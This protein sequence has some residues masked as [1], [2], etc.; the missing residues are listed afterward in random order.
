[1]VVPGWTQAKTVTSSTTIS[2][3][4]PVGVKVMTTV[5]PS[6]PGGKVTVSSGFGSVMVVGVPTV[7]PFTSFT[8]TV[9]VS[10]PLVVTVMLSSGVSSSET[11]TVTL[12]LVSSVDGLQLP[13]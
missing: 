12:G 13:G 3:V 8:V 4:V 7:L 6:V 2:S 10:T 5:V 11:V 9:M 1:M